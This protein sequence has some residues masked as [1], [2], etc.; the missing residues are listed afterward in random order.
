MAPPRTVHLTEPEAM[1]V[2]AH[3]TRLRLLAALR[4]SGPASVGALARAVDEAPGSVSYHLGRLADVGFVEEAADRARDRRERWWR[5]VH[6]RTTIDS[7][8]DR[9][10]PERMAAS[11]AL[12]R[13]VAR[14]YAELQEAYLD[15]EPSLPAHWVAAGTQGDRHWHLTAEELRAFSAELESVLARWQERSDASRDGTRAVA[16]VYSAFLRPPGAP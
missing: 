7:V 13:Q 12:R 14:R 9:A 1:R 4:T 16:V 8:E 5:A 3:P 6:E 11:T 2:L 10:D 15:A